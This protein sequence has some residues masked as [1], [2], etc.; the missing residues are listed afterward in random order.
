MAHRSFSVPFADIYPL[1]LAKIERKGRQAAELEA[2]LTWF[3]G[4]ELTVQRLNRQHEH[5]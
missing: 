1:Y 3:S 2:V 5:S 4:P